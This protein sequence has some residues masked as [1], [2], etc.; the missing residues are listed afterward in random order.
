MSDAPPTPASTRRRRAPGRPRRDEADAARQSVLD[1]ALKVFQQRGFEAASMEG[2]ARA[3][4]VAKLT[5]YRHFETKDQ[6]FVEV[7][8]R[9]QVS[10]RER[11]GTM[12][13]HGRPL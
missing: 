9:A 12:V 1:A 2:I 11:L 7:A 10:V 3:A 4:G 5:L 13:D 8:R 6:L